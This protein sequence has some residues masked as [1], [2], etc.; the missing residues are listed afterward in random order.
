MFVASEPA[1]AD[2]LQRFCK[3]GVD[4][5]AL[6]AMPVA[7]FMNDRMTPEAARDALRSAAI[8]SQRQ[9]GRARWASSKLAVFGIGLGLVTATVGL[10]E[11]KPRVAA[12]SPGVVHRRRA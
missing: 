9:Y 12:S 10:I 8:G 3:P 11:S 1:S 6:A 2:R 7:A 4:A 5:W